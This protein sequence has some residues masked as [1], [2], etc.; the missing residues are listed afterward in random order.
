M[1]SII[2]T[3]CPECG[4]K[5]YWCT[6]DGITYCDNDGPT[7]CRAKA[8]KAGLPPHGSGM[9]IENPGYQ[10]PWHRGGL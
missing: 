6:D 7:G 10:P 2:D 1:A 8:E 5:A 9:H 4:G 3:T